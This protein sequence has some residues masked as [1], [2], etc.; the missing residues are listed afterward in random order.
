MKKLLV[1]ALASVFATSAFAADMKW[2]GSAA[3]RFTSKTQQDGT[4][5][6]NTTGQSTAKDTQK[7]LGLRG[8]FGFTGGWD[9]ISYGVG[10]RTGT[11]STVSDWG[12]YASNSADFPVSL[13]QAWM[14]YSYDTGYGDLGMTF[15]RAK[16]VFAQDTQSQQLFDND[17]RFNGLGWQW[18]WGS[19]GFNMAQYTL[20]ARNAGTTDAATYTYTDSTQ[21]AATT[22]SHFAWIYGFQPNMSWKFS[23]EI[24]TFF[25][26]GYYRFSGDDGRFTNRIHGGFSPLDLTSASALTAVNTSK[27]GVINVDNSKIVQLYNTWNLPYR[28]KANVEVLLN[29]KYKYSAVNQTN[30]TAAGAT[31]ADFG[32]NKTSSTAWTVGLQY[33]AV[34]KPHDFML[35]Y[36]YGVKGLTSVPGALTYSSFLPDNKGHTIDAKYA[37]ATNFVLAWKG[38]FLK[39]QSRKD[40]KGDA[41]TT[42]QEHK[43]N[44]WDVSAIVSF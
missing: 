38:V 13:E 35:G 27:S 26:V 11:G 42:A 6:V 29:K 12:N 15:G 44:Y 19:F 17:M 3:T 1:L 14:K 33:G 31:Q 22:K 24:D 30:G 21:N 8:N 40:S 2:N 7:T 37:L 16:S 9:N 28:L 43:S 23:D 20:G 39:E 32:A 34:A 4:A 18:K 41:V 10:M 36:A 25:A 5:T